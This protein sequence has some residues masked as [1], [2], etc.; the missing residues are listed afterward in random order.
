[1]CAHTLAA[2]RGKADELRGRGDFA[3]AEKCL[4]R[5]AKDDPDEPQNLVAIAELRQAAGDFDGALAMVDRARSHPKASAA[6]RA[7]LDDLSGDLAW[8]AG[9]PDDARKYWQAAAAAPGD[10]AQKRTLRA[11]LIAAGDARLREPLTRFF[12]GVPPKWQ[13][14]PALDLWFA[15]QAQ[16]AAPELG[17]PVYLGGRGLLL[18]DDFVDAV[19]PLEKARELGLPDAAFVREDLRVTGL[20]AYRAG[21]WD[22]AAKNFSELLARKDVPEGTRI[23][24]EDW[25]DRLRFE[26]HLTMPA[27]S[28]TLRAPKAKE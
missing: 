10:E 8:R 6:L 9:K 7:H 1:V 24:A 26:G 20:A 21:D 22:R 2:L 3:D 13:R 23:E 27:N 15:A 25:L 18:R 19:A 14:D 5:I 28:G 4:D 17:L 11:K 16:M 12:L